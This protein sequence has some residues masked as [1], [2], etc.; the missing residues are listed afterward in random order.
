MTLELYFI[1]LLILGVSYIIIGN[2]VYYKAMHALDVP[3]SLLP[4]EQFKHMREYRKM[5]EA[6]GEHPWFMFF[7]KNIKAILCF[8][9]VLWIPFIILMILQKFR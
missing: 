8:Y 6:K 1:I 7:L 3:L 4:S 2:Y 5:L 9:V